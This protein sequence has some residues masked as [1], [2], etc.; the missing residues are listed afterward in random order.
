MYQ[1]FITISILGFIA[2]SHILVWKWAAYLQEKYAT[3]KKKGIRIMFG[4]MMLMAALFFSLAF[5]LFQ[6]S[7]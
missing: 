6:T 1:L 5:V 2:M 3:D 7:T 4:I